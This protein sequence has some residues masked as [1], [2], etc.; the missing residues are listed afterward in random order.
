M[1][2]SK[3]HRMPFAPPRSCSPT[4]AGCLAASCGACSAVAAPPSEGALTD[5]ETSPAAGHLPCK[6]TRCQLF[7]STVDIAS[8]CLWG[9]VINAVVPVKLP[10][11]PVAAWR[12][13]RRRCCRSRCSCCCLLSCRACCSRLRS[14]SLAGKRCWMMSRNRVQTPAPRGATEGRAV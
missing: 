12:R 5:E 9:A 10:A 13:C 2:Q 11:S 6:S 4:A 1:I 3:A 7:I 8:V 14:C